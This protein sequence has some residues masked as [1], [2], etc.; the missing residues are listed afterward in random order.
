MNSRKRSLARLQQLRTETDLAEHELEKHRGRFVKLA[1]NDSAP[2]AVSAF[3]LFQTPPDI[4][5]MMAGRLLEHFGNLD[6]LRLLEPSA[7]LGRLYSAVR[8]ASDSAEIVLVEQ[9]ADCCRELYKQTES[10]RRARLIQSDFLA[11]DLARAGGLF[12]VVIANPPFKQGRDVKHI[13]HA[14]ELL[15]PGGLLVSLCFD[16]VKQNRNLRPRCDT[17]EVLPDGS[18]KSEGTGA[19]VVLLS[20]VRK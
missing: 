14:L 10:D 4:A 5:A 18:F 7:G 13:N 11:V 17:W 1:R 6:G 20:I 9:S 15:K 19:S 3:N 8:S 2:R 16:G 12:D